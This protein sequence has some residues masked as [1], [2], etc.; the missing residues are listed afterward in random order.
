M[1]SSNLSASDFGCGC[2][3]GCCDFELPPKFF[4]ELALDS[5]SAYLIMSAI[6]APYQY[7]ANRKY[8]QHSLL[9][10]TLLSQFINPAAIDWMQKES[11]LFTLLF[12]HDNF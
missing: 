6:I 4:N 3:C 2:G 11:D 10:L 8:Q 12:I 7:N 9:P 1:V 5:E